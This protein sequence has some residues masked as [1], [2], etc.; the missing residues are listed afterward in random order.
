MM[1]LKEL[2]EFGL[3]ERIRNAAGRSDAIVGIGDDCAAF[4]VPSGTV[5][6][7]STDM[8]LEEVHFRSA[9][10]DY[11]SIGCKSVAVNVSDIAAMGGTPQAIFMG[12]AAPGEMS[13]EQLES[14]VRG[15]REE[16]RYYGAELLGGDTCRSPSGLVLGITVQGYVPEQQIVTRS[17]ARGGDIIWV[18]G[19]LGD[20]GLALKMLQQGQQPPEVLAMRH[21]RP[22]AQ[23]ALG[24]ALAKRD[25]A[26]AM[27]DISD[28]LLADLG[29]ILHAS[30][31]GAEIDVRRLPLSSYMQHHLTRQPEDLHLA[32]RGGE[33]YELLFCSAEERGAEL[34]ELSAQL[35]VPLTPIGEIRQTSGLGVVGANDLGSELKGE[36][37]DH[38]VSS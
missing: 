35:E 5:P 12:L 9:W 33:D 21:H 28:G 14:L 16:S 10:S 23:V 26:T 7:V 19:S 37:Y 38:F 36:G 11:Y 17:G 1:Q 20:S 25:L 2:G 22:R 32:L 15:V 4:R 18:S 13:V 31:V 24:R 6:L 27:I 34:R 3:I 30:E 8:L 29:H